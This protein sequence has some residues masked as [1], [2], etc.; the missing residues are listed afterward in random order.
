MELKNQIVYSH[1]SHEQR[2]DMW[3]NSQN[4]ADMIEKLTG[5]TGKSF[6]SLAEILLENDVNYLRICAGNRARRD[7][8]L[9]P[10]DYVTAGNKSIVVDCGAF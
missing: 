1:L 2:A 7:F 6:Y 3:L 5:G 9:I 4:V 10:G 8:N